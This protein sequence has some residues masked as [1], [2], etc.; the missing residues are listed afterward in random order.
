VL[1][2][3]VVPPRGEVPLGLERAVT[4]GGEQLAD[5]L[6]SAAPRRVLNE[7]IADQIDELRPMSDVKA[8]SESMDERLADIASTISAVRKD[9]KRRPTATEVADLKPI[10]RL[11]TSDADL[12]EVNRKLEKSNQD[13]AARVADLARRLEQLETKKGN[14]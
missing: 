10:K 4:P 8:I 11:A 3:S 1:D 13:L 9:L 2:Q 12:R 6:R 5:A 7:L 14:A